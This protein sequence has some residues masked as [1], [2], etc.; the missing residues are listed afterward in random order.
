MDIDVVIEIPRGGR[1]KYEWDEQQRVMRFNRR[2]PGAVSFPADYGFVPETRAADD[3]PL[4][5]LVLLEEPSFPGIWVSARPVGVCWVDA[6]KYCEP[7]LICVPVS[8]PRHHMTNDLA[9]L[10]ASVVDEIRQ[11]FD[12]YKE[13][14]DGHGSKAHAFEGHEAACDVVRD[15]RQAFAAH[16]SSPE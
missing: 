5:A 2:I 10:P 1:N 14:E 3:D 4:D 9:D 13:L 7:K 6:E 15:A 12:T 8:E 11:F 16:N